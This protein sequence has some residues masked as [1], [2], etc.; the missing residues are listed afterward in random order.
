[1]SSEAKAMEK[2][3][4]TKKRRTLP[5]RDLKRLRRSELLEIMID[6][7]REINSLQEQLDEANAKLAEREIIIQESGSIAEAA[8]RLNHIFED[9]Q[10]AADL[11]LENIRRMNGEQADE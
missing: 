5:E 2:K 8:L 1:M 3:T 7:V 6:Q 10:R 11:Y 4:T 9:A